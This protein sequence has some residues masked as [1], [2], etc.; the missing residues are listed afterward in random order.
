MKVYN[1][2]MKYDVNNHDVC[3]NCDNEA[4][5]FHLSSLSVLQFGSTLVG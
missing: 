3:D 2:K 5:N 1:N 4:I